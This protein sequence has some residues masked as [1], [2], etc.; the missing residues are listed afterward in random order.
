MST[1]DLG[2]GS[3]EKRATRRLALAI[4]ALVVGVIVALAVYAV[5]S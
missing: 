3:A 1:P 2:E 5:L 4:G